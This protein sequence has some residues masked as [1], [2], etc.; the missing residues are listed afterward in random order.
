MKS[1]AAVTTIAIDLAKNVFQLALA[2]TS[3]RIV[4]SLRLK[5]ADFLLFW[6][7]HAMVHV[8]ME[9]CGS[10]HHF[11]R[12]LTS[13]GHRVTLLPP[14][15]VRPY[16]RRNKTDAAD[17]AALLEALRASDIKPVPIKTEHQQVIQLMHRARQQWQRD[18]T[19]RINLARGMLREFGV[20]VPEGAERGQSAMRA[21]LANELL[22]PNI[23]ALLTDVLQEIDQFEQRVLRLDRALAA[24]SQSDPV[25]V[26]LES[27]PGIGWITATAIR[28][29]IGDI[30]RFKDG[31]S[32]SSWIGFTPKESSS[33]STRKLG[34]MTKRGDVYV[35]TLLIQGARSVLAAA[36]RK[37]QSGKPLDALRLWAITLADRRGFNKAAVGLANKLARILWATWRH[38]RVFDADHALSQRI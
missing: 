10:A 17:C 27:L 5:R 38:D 21:Q 12:W 19:A 33:G 16:V 11:G 8:V 37:V 32:L 34:R 13:M 4:R 31:R 20:A 26:K 25:L 28:A 9:A 22:N 14:E 29:S 24:L 23:R 2:D 30:H 35:R 36:R 3:F 1:T 7:N 6:S 15:Y 18:R